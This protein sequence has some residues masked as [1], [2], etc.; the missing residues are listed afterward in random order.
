MPVAYHLHPATPNIGN[1]LIVLATQ[2]LLASVN[3]TP[4]DI[5]HMPAKGVDAVLKRGGLNR[6]TVYD[7]NHL[8]TGILVGPGN[9]FE[10]NGLDVDLMALRALRR[11]L[12]LFGISAGRIFDAKGQMHGR[13]DAMPDSMIQELVGKASATLVRDH[14]TRRHLESLGLH[15]I[16]VVGCPVLALNPRTLNL[17]PPDPRAQGAALISIRHPDLMNVPPRLQGQV[18]RDVPRLIEGLREQGHHKI[19]LLCHDARDIRFAA[20]H[21]VP[22]LY[23]EDPLRYL[24]WLRDCRLNVTFRVHSLLPCAVLGTPAVHFTYDERAKGL[25]DVAGLQ[26]CS[27][28]YITS[29]D[30]VAEA[31]AACARADTLRDHMATARQ[32]W[33]PLQ[34]TMRNALQ[35]WA[36]RG[37]AA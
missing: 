7:A 8:A 30:P 17:S 35:D 24:S 2:Q 29:H 23:T 26:N 1:H 20:H 37:I 25:I 22:F 18:H 11:P 14:A 3:E 21:D 34:N 9:L 12:M 6:E 31:L 13:S 19:A 27:I 4:L 15:N 10:N 5:L 33:N 28:D 16:Q 32:R 36:H